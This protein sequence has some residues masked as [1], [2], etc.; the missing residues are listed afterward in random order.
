MT[1]VNLLLILFG[2]LA[3]VWVPVARAWMRLVAM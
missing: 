1:L 2:A 3:K